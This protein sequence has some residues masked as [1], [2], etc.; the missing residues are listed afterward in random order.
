MRA[1]VLLDRD[2]PPVEITGQMASGLF[3]AAFDPWRERS[4]P[5]HAIGQRDW[6]GKP[7]RPIAGGTMA[8]GMFLPTFIDA[9][10]ATQ[11]AV[12]LSLTTHKIAL[13][14]NSYTP[15]FS[16]HDQFADVTNEV[17]GS[18]YTAGGR[19]L[20]VGASGGGAVTPVFVEGPTGSVKYDF[21]DFVWPSPT[22]VTA[23]G[24]VLY[25]DALTGDP[26]LLSHT[27]GSDITST[28]G[29]FTIAWASGGLV[30]FDLTP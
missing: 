5:F 16:T 13:V 18:G 9:F 24:E 23:R 10:D 2:E 28:A 3:L 6:K 7:L 21:D 30:V 22:S 11:L 29:T 20:S 27:F 1:A 15:D 25:L 8:S 17:S 4:V 26:L 12:D 19:L 14:T